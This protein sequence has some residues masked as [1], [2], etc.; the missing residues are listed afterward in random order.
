MITSSLMTTSSTQSHKKSKFFKIDIF[1]GI[2]S[3]DDDADCISPYLL[4]F[5]VCTLYEVA[6]KMKPEKHNRVNA[7]DE[8]SKV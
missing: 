3:V 7:A 8:Q 1:C 4:I 5:A 6:A 2:E